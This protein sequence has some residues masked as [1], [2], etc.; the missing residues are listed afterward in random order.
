MTPVSAPTTSDTNSTTTPPT[1]L[2]DTAPPQMTSDASSPPI[3][4]YET[5]PGRTMLASR[6][7]SIDVIGLVAAAGIVLVDTAKSVPL[8]SIGH[9]FRF[10]VQF[11]VFASLYF[12]AQS[13]R[14]NSTRTFSK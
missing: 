13:L 2:L 8:I 12:Q 4:T 7:E 10:A 9:F 1:P 14:R 5:P 6:T 11:Y 3:L